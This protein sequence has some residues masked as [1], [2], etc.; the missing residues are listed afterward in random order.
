[1][2]VKILENLPEL[3]PALERLPHRRVGVEVTSSS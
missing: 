3:C 2:R 1:L